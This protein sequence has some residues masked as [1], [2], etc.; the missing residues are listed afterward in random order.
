MH[1]LRYPKKH[2]EN[3]SKCTRPWPTQYTVIFLTFERPIV[4]GLLGRK[5][6][7]RKRNKSI[8]KKLNGLIFFFSNKNI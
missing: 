8:L 6:R 5:K 1:V 7:N 4:R 3:P 2:Y